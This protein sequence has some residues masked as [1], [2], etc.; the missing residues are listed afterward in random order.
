M[1][2]RE[3][4]DFPPN[5]NSNALQDATTS[6]S[7]S[8]LKDPR[9]VRVSRALGGKDRHSKVCT[10]RGLRDRRVRLS[11][12][13]AIQLYDL[14]ERLGLSQPSKVVDWL[15]DAAK[16][17]IDELPPLQIPHALM[18]DFSDHA[19]P[20]VKKEGETSQMN[21]D[22]YNDDDDNDDR[23]N[24]EHFDGLLQ[25]QQ[26]PSSS[27][28]RLLSGGWDP[29][30]LTLSSPHIPITIGLTGNQSHHQDLH[31]FG[32]VYH[33]SGM[34]APTPFCTP[35]FSIANAAFDH[36]AVARPFSFDVGVDREQSKRD[37]LDGK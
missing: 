23:G 14:Q 22:R 12:P 6:S 3:P 35:H 37:D 18:L 8:R 11:V 26:N 2:S 16:H 20:G 27:F 24:D 19:K 28:S 5:K 10:V 15:L 36:H 32:V 9:I 13:T 21:G 7:W 34:M 4:D 17:E 31:N 25:R 1:I 30:S 33:Q 29:S